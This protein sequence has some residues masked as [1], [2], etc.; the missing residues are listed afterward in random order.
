MS[1]LVEVC[2][3]SRERRIKSGM[4]ASELN[5]VCIYLLERYAYSQLSRCG[6]VRLGPYS[7]ALTHAN[8]GQDLGHAVPVSGPLV[9]HGA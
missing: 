7:N 8:L 3:I 9:L 5:E 4:L 6:Y 2:C 1:K